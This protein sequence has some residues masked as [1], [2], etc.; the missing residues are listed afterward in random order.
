MNVWMRDKIEFKNGNLLRG[1]TRSQHSTLQV[2]NRMA[3]TQER[4]RC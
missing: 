1:D 4:P 3:L 2:S